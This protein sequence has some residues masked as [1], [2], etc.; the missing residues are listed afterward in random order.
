MVGHKGPAAGPTDHG[1]NTATKWVPGSLH[2]VAK[3]DRNRTTGTGFQNLQGRQAETAQPE[4]QVVLFK[5]DMPAF[6]FQSPQGPNC[7]NGQFASKGLA[8]LHATLHIKTLVFV[9][10]FSGF[11]R[12]HDLHSL[13]DHQTWGNVHFFTLSID[14][15]MQKVEG[16]L[17]TSQAFQFWMRQIGSGQIIGMGGGPP[18]ETFTAAR[19]LEGGPPP[20]RSG[21][22]MLGFPNLRS[23]AWNQAMVGSRLIWFLLEALLRLALMGGCGFLEH[24]Q[25]PLWA[26]TKDPSSI[27]TLHE[28]RLLRTLEC[29]GV[30]SFDQ[31]T[32]GSPAIKPTTI[33][34]L[35][36]PALRTKLLSS[37]WGGRCNHGAGAH[38]RMAGRSETGEFRTAKA[39]I[40]PPG[41]NKALADAIH[42][43]VCD[44]F[45][46]QTT[47]S[48]LP[49]DFS[50]YVVEDFVPMDVVQPDYHGQIL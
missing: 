27:W 22:Y 47:S 40:Y 43:M 46:S 39:K 41:L 35:R 8:A 48:R 34:H 18:C 2:H 21:T 11:R 7:G 1:T 15:C 16:N 3:M 26:A 5:A 36:L 13:L 31:C 32:C 4:P 38:E 9:H 19:L 42:Q 25:F 29:V 30:T 17:A 20:I 45:S 24:P 14:M 50:S 10:V 44:V 6:V 12:K 49:E 37:G 28:V 23:W 33:L